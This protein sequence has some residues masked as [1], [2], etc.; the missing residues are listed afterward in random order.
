MASFEDVRDAE[1]K[2]LR[3]IR[4]RAVS[5]A[6]LRGKTAG[7]AF[8]GGGIRSATFHLGVLETLAEYGLLKQFDYLST[9]SGGGYIGSWLV[10]WIQQEGITEV[11]RKLPGVPQEAPQVNFLRDYSNFLTPRKGLLGADTWAA[12]ATYLRNVL[13]NQAILVSFLGALLFL[14]WILGGLFGLGPY[15]GPQPL[16]LSIAAGALIVLAVGSG[17][18]NIST[19]SGGKPQWFAHQTWVLFTV[20][21]P[22]FAGAFLL[23]YAIWRAP[24]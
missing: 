1:K 9:V 15:E 2:E 24:G 10:R 20:V 7:L 16:E 18:L 12:I 14:P 6:R 13:L 22:L 4:D 3:D 19:C 5:E 21:L 23:N 8:S 17:T 11:E